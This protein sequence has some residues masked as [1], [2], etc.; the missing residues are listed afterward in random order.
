MSQLRASGR[1]PK[2]IKF[3][4]NRKS[5]RKLLNEKNLNQRRQQLIPQPSNPFL[6]LS[7][8][9]SCARQLRRSLTTQLITMNLPYELPTRVIRQTFQL[10]LLSNYSDAFSTLNA[11]PTSQPKRIRMRSFIIQSHIHN[12]HG[13]GTPLP[14]K[15][16]YSTLVYASI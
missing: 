1:T 2:P 16:F 4:M 15:R 13:V 6:Y 10:V 3:L 5:L 14:R 8:H 9:Q 11:L 7:W 12:T